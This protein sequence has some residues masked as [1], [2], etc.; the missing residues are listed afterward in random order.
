MTGEDVL[1]EKRLLEKNAKTTKCECL[2]LGSELKKHTDIAKTQYQ[3]LGK[4]FRDKKTLKSI[5]NQI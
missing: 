2:P 1:P 5:I 4:V 3:R